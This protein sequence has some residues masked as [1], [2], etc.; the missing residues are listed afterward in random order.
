MN[1][2]SHR[3]A[4]AAAAA[5]EA[6]TSFANARY[7][8]RYA[9]FFEY[10]SESKY[11]S[12]L[13]CFANITNIAAA[14]LFLERCMAMFSEFFI[15][16]GC[17]AITDINDVEAPHTH[18]LVCGYNDNAIALRINENIAI[19]TQSRAERNSITP[20]ANYISIAWQVAKMMA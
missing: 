20:T 8:I 15:L 16:N 6:N 3:L 7:A 5:A 17:R 13:L 14:I 11:S 1:R 19:S 10:L 12:S 2:P 9:V 18:R 4:G